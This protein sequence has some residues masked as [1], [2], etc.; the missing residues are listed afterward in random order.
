MRTKDE[1]IQDFSFTDES[2]LTYESSKYEMQCL[3]IEVLIDIR[4]LMAKKE[5]AGTDP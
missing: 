5:E 1:M 2:G 3:L 4:D